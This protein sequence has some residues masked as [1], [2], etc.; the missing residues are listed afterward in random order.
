MYPAAPLTFPGMKPR[1]FIPLLGVGVLLIGSGIAIQVASADEHPVLTSQYAEAGFWS[2]GLIGTFTIKNLTSK[3][4]SDWKLSFGLTDHAELAGVWNGKL[5]TPKAGEYTITPTPQTNPVPAGGALTVGFTALTDAHA[6]PVNCLINGKSCKIVIGN[7]T[8]LQ[9]SPSDA[10]ATTPAGTADTQA[11]GGIQVPI[12]HRTAAAG[13]DTPVTGPATAPSGV[14]PSVTMPAGGRPPL[15]ELAS[16]GKVHALNLLSAVPSAA[17][18]CDLKWGGVQDLTTYAKEIGDAVT[19]KIALIGDVGAGS[20][21]D[22]MKTCGTAAA[23]EAQLKKL[24]AM[25]ITNLDLTIPAATAA[26]QPLNLERARVVRDLKA[27]F[28]ALTVAYTLPATVANLDSPASPLS[29]AKGLLDRVNVVPVDLSQ[30]PGPLDSLLSGLG[31]GDTVTPLL[32]AAKAVHGKLMS[33]QGLDS[34]S[35]WKMIGL[36]PVIGGDDLLGASSTAG[37]VQKLA[38]FTRS[39]GLGMLGFLPLGIDGSCSS[40]A[41]PVSLPVLDCLDANVLPH[42]FALTQ[43]FTDA[44]R[45]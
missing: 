29:A 27:Q 10:A 14:V 5:T 8:G 24:V 34:A 20:P 1:T 42:F 35:A 32:S 9:I 30:A 33:L 7:G 40:G 4:S 22:L 21:L 25:G 11:S 45:Q 2:G 44:L 17:G 36:V 26:D 39:N 18:A 23:A 13:T 37:T 12:P 41:L 43:T 16:A 15:T 28:P 19:A 31:L 6:I 3:P 38:D